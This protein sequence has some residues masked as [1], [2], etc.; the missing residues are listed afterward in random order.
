M[1]QY[2][3]CYQEKKKSVSVDNFN[4]RSYFTVEKSY[5]EF[6]VQNSKENWITSFETKTSMLQSK[7][8]GIDNWNGCQ[9]SQRNFKVFFNF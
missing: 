9:A 8:Y 7:N 2:D 6:R 5:E 3:V 1:L 4:I